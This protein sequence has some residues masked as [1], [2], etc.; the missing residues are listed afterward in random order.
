[1]SR[2]S[3]RRWPGRSGRSTSTGASISGP[4][5]SPA[6]GGTATPPSCTVSTRWRWHPSARTRHNHPVPDP[7]APPPTIAA[8]RPPPGSD[9]DPV[10]RRTIAM[11]VFLRDDYFAV[12]GTLTDERP[13]AG[14]TLG[15]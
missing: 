2:P 3:R 12:V 14:G 8:L 5:R 15:P 11:D 7:A 10:H 9:E 4:P 1:M 6:S 13:W